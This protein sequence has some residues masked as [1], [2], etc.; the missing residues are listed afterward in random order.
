MTVMP[1]GGFAIRAGRPQLLL[2]YHR[3]PLAQSMHASKILPHCSFRYAQ[4]RDL[5]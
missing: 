5:T 1:D 2:Q 4:P 3:W